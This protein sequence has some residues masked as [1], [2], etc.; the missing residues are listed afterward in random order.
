MKIV[1]GKTSLTGFKK[2]YG[3]IIA[4]RISNIDIYQANETERLL[5]FSEIMPLLYKLLDYESYTGIWL[6]NFPY[7][8]VYEQNRDHILVEEKYRGEK[9]SRCRNCKYYMLCPGFPTGYFERFSDRELNPVADLPY[10][11]MIE[12]ETK[13]NLNCQFCYNH[14]SFAEYNRNQ[15]AMAAPVLKKIID[16]IANAG[17]KI[18]RF[19]GG[20]PLL[21]NDIFKLFK[22]AKKLGLAVWL[23]TNASLVDKSNINKFSGLVDNILLP[24]ES[25][26]NKKEAAV[27]GRSDSLALKL[28]AIKLFKRIGI[29]IIR[30]GTVA[31]RENIAEFDRIAEFILNLPINGWELYRPISS[32]RY[33]ASLT[34]RDIELL[35]R[36]IVKAGNKSNKKITIANAVP[37]CGAKDRNLLNSIGNGAIFEDGHNR[38][39]I[40]PR[41]FV[42]PHYF[43]D[44]DLGRPLNILDA[45]RHSFMKKMRNL[46]FLP[47]ECRDCRFKFKCRGGSRYEARLA[48][49]R[50]D[51]LDPL[52]NIKN[53]PVFS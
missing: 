52:A 26:D 36:G 50:W 38:L 14:N 53:K 16:N 34:A 24:I 29:P 40:D 31:S 18:V 15:K 2:V 11:V 19:T 48:S 39:V 35:V 10:E 49:G 33:R 12:A 4:N 3:G 8:V 32:K 47:K 28:R 6:I 22:Y 5:K 41:G 45:W 1:L 43:I 27:T 13:C 21:R 30:L 23:N 9:N 37:F 25:Y 42:K 46:E 51:G 44:R 17:I 20:E 7:C